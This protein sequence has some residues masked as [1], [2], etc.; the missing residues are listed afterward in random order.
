MS[1]AP[2]PR[3]SAAVLM[4]VAASIVAVPFG[5]PIP[6]EAAAP[7]RFLAAADAFVDGSR[8]GLRTGYRKTL[9]L[10]RV[11]EQRSLVRFVVAGVHGRVIRATLR[12]FAQDASP[13]GFR[14]FGTTTNDWRES[15]VRWVDRPPRATSV[16]RSG[17]FRAGSWTSVDVTSVVSGNGTFSFVLT[18]ASNRRIRL[19]SRETSR[20]P[21]LRVLSAPDPG[22]VVAAAGDIACDPEGASFNAGRGVPG[23]CRMQATSDILLANRSRLAAVLALGD[24]QYEDG[25]LGD[26]QA[27]Y[28][29][30]WGRVLDITL[31]AAGNHEY[32]TPGAAGYFAYFGARAGDPDEGWYA[33]T[34]GTW[35][36][37]VLNSECGA[38][39]GC[40][41]SSPQG[42]W[43]AT[44]LAAGPTACTLAAWH[45]PRF[46]STIY[47]EPARTAELWEMLRMA[48]VDVVVTGHA[49]GYERFAPI[50]AGDAPD[51]AY[52]MR[53]FVAGTG[54]ANLHSF[55]DV[56]AGSK[57]RGSRAFGVLEMTLRD[58]GY[59]WRMVPEFGLKVQDPGSA[60]CHAA[61]PS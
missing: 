37:I 46:S 10:N 24:T 55:L 41:A 60:T 31:P 13:S 58:G 17:G 1:R 25:A 61:P 51:L 33:T 45:V 3:L 6:A 21:R 57:Y 44:E 42:M 9:R 39:G 19:A 15:A 28:A 56:A 29:P 23:R 49:H 40:E 54:G 34:I 11:P 30:S 47:D 2:R 4:I 14:V 48:G 16:G 53:Q 52:G 7:K 5:D 22:P 8:P 18:T 43:L 27:S 38:I 36:V 59:D 32:R 26:F 12:V 50:G 20:D 35:R